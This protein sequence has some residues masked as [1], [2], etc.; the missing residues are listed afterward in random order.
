MKLTSDKLI[1]EFIAL[2]TMFAVLCI[3]KVFQKLNH[4]I[5]IIL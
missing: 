5:T 3:L 1:I 4:K 2:K